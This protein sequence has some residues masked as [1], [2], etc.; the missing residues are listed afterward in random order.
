MRTIL[1]AAETA[2]ETEHDREK[3]SAGKAEYSGSGPGRECA[4]KREI[5]KTYIERYDNKKGIRKTGRYNSKKAKED[6]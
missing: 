4:G 2:T 3:R 5:R 1:Q 6:K